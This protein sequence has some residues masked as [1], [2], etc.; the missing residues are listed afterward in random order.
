MN[1]NDTH[2]IQV[3]AKSMMH[4]SFNEAK[5]VALLVWMKAYQQ[6]KTHSA[7]DYTI[8]D[9]HNITGLHFET[10]KKRLLALEKLGMLGYSE[11]K[12]HY[13]FLRVKTH[14]NSRN[15]QIAINRDTTIKHTEKSMLVARLQMKLRQ[16][17]FIRNVFSIAQTGC[18]INGK[19][20][21]LQQLK[22]ARKY[23]R[24]HCMTDY[25]SNEFKDNGWSYKAIAE[26]LGVSIKKAFEI[27][28][29]AVTNNVITKRTNSICKRITS[30][31]DTYYSECTFVFHGYMYKVYANTYAV[32]TG[33]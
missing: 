16:K 11:R 24:E 1:N 27:V 2:I 15:I 20:V 8:S 9:L 5:A 10:V 32:T 19:S 14:N 3:R 17:E 21:K 4:L 7:K 23:L 6:R 13:T 30:K 18:D 25:R 31:L 28:S 12:D 33:Q 26:Y 29:Y 22:R